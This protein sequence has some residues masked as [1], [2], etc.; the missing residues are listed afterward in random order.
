MLDGM[1]PEEF[2]EW[3]AYR[4]LEP[5]PLGRIAEILKLGFVAVCGAWGLNLTPDTFDPAAETASP[6][7]E[8]TPNQGAQMVG[9]CLGRPGRR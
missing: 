5:D 2:D 7:A 8:V 4:E 9:S 3:R 6:V 1:T